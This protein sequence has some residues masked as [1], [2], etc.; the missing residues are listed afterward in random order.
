M[1]IVRIL[2]DHCKTCG[3]CVEACPRHALRIGTRLNAHGFNFV[4][5]DSTRE[6]SGCGNCALVCP[7][8]A[9]ELFAEAKTAAGEG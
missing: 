9:I 6:C 7:D 3:V 5:F 4:E 2:E 8:A 1:A